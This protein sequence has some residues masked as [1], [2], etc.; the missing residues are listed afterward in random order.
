M[1][2]KRFGLAAL[3]TAWLAACGGGGG[4][5]AAVDA[6]AA[7]DGTTATRGAS[8]SG[9]V[10][11]TSGGSAGTDVLV[12]DVADANGVVPDGAPSTDAASDAADGGGDAGTDAC[13]CTQ[14]DDCVGLGGAC[15]VAVCSACQCSVN[16]LADGTPCEDGDACT[17]GD[18]CEQG[19]CVA[20]APRA[21]DDGDPCT[22]DGCDPAVG[23]THDPAPD[24]GPC[25]DGDACT[26]GDQCV[27]G[28]CQGVAAVDCDDGEPCTDDTCD[29]ATG[30]AHAPATGPACDDGD[31][32]TANDACVDGACTGEPDPTCG[33]T[34]TCATD[35]DCVGAGEDPCQPAVCEGCQCVVTSLADG[36]PCEDGDLCTTGDT[37]QAGAC[38]SGPALD[39]DDANPCTVDG[40]SPAAGCFHDPA[41]NG[42]PCDD[43]MPCNGEDGCEDGQCLG[44]PCV[45]H[46]DANCPDDGNP[47]NGVPSCGEQG[48]CVAGEPVVCAATSPCRVA[49]CDPA[50]GS[51]VEE[52][53]ADGTPCDDGDACTQ[54]DHCVAGE[55]QPGPD[56]CPPAPCCAAHEEAG[57]ED[58]PGCA[59]CVCLHEPTCCTVAWDAGC[60]ACAQGLDCGV[61]LVP[62]ASCADACECPPP[63]GCCEAHED[64]TCDDAKCSSCVCAADPSC[65]EVAWNEACV[66]LAAGVD[67]SAACGCEPP[68]P[69]SCCEAGPGPGCGDD[70]CEACVCATQLAC[71]QGG[72]W[73][74]DCVGVATTECAGACGCAPG[75]CCEPHEG[76]GCDTA[77]CQDCVC[78]EQ[79]ICCTAAW[80]ASCVDAAKLLCKAPCGCD[81]PQG[82]TCCEPH[83]GTGCDDP[84]CTQCVCGIDSF[85]CNSLWDSI[86]ADEATNECGTSCPCGGGGGPPPSGCCTS[87][88]SP[89]CG[90]A[91]CEQCVCGDTGLNPFCCQV[92]WDTT[93]VDTASQ[94]CAEV[95]GCSGGPPPPPPPPSPGACC[96]SL[97]T[98]GCPADAPCETCVCAG[99]PACCSTA[100]DDGCWKE[101]AYGCAGACGCAVTCWPMLLCVADCAQGDQACVS[102]CLAAGSGASQ[103]L[104]V[105]YA[106][107]VNDNCADLPQDQVQGCVIDKCLDP[108]LAC[109]QD[110]GG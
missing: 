78:G 93:C 79:P 35:D 59:T 64:P 66:A 85:C 51:C 89:N 60:V 47:C 7:A 82:G 99:N 12:A 11:D 108:F 70:A 65:C 48:E 45:C 18:A 92:A 14:D 5:G 38:T 46:T 49:A 72:A 109:L 106:T 105:D 81:V 61:P 76:S 55:C 19:A 95:C 80:D 86:C 6:G 84:A 2:L 73:G 42:T 26:A 57:C 50:S 8:D 27:G 22:L 28:E 107:C 67:C 32:C 62:D 1:W 71:C 110:G 17:K 69:P 77:A 37:C 63:G 43:G 25:D 15:S 56:T 53:V 9:V 4:S 13:D 44:A 94:A 31:P 90:D 40:C 41:P 91:A 87:S 88:Q 29:A 54:G 21:C 97:G 33:G 103:Q 10:S 34:C 96:D 100:W 20:G 36:I 24:G 58:V 39:C 68:P 101:A 75:S 102:Q 104:L 74:A 16:P 23:C 30:C 98:P 3:A 83:D 52:P